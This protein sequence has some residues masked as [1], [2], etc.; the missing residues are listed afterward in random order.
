MKKYSR[1]VMFLFLSVLTV[2]IGSCKKED[3][4]E[5]ARS[6][7]AC[8]SMAADGLLA[9][10]DER[11]HRFNGKVEENTALCRGGDKAARYRDVPWMDW[12]NYWG[13]GDASSKGPDKTSLDHLS[14]TG[15]G[16]DGALLDLEYQ[17]MELIEFNLFDNYTYKEYVKGIEGR[18]GDVIK[19]WDEM[20]LPADH[21][22][23]QDVGG[24]GEQVCD[25][26]L[27][28]NR[29][30]T[31]VCN[32][33]MNPLMGSTNTLFARNVQ[34]ETS[35][36]M[37]GETELV[38]NRHGDRLGLLKPD[39]QLI[40]RRLFTRQQSDAAAC[41]NGYGSESSGEAECD[42]I[43]APFFNVLAAFWIQ[44]M[45]HDWFS[46]LQD[47]HNQ[48]EYMKVGCDSD[49]AE[50][51][52]CRPDDMME[53]AYVAEDS[54]P[55][56]FTYKGESYLDRAPKTFRNTNTAWWDAS[57]IYGYDEDSR[58]R[59]KRDPQDTAK[60]LMTPRGDL[61]GAGDAQGYLPLLLDS[62]PMNPAWAG[63]AA[64]GF[65][66]NWTIGMSFYH[67]VFAREHNAFVE[68][69]REHAKASPEADSGLRDPARPG[70]VIRN[71][72]VSDDEL[73][74]V[75]RLVIAAEIA[76][77]HTIEWTT[78]LLYN[79]P[80]YRGMNANWGGLLDADANQAVQKALAK[81][82][83][84]FSESDSD[85]ANKWYSIFASGPG[86][87]GLGSKKKGWDLSNPKDVN[88]GVNHFGAPFNFPE[89][90]ITVYRLHP[91]LPDALENRVLDGDPNKIISKTPIV[92]SF[93]GKA[94][95]VMTS[96][97]LANTAL[98][99]G[100]QRLGLLTLGNHPNFLQNL[101]MK[102]L[103]TETQEIDVAAL[104]LIR[105]RE[106]GVPR[107]NEFRRQYGLKQL[108]SFN[109]FVDTRLATGSAERTRQEE[110]VLGMREVYGQH[111]CDASK[112]I[113][114]AQANEDG[115][116]IND[117]LGHPDGTTV[118]NI[119]D[120]DAVVGW[121]AEGPRPH[122]FAI[123]ETQFVV[124]I[125]NASRRLYSDRFFTSSYRPE[126]YTK[127][128]I[129]WV[130]NNGPDGK[131]MEKGE[132]NGHEQQVS[133]MKRVLWRT[134]PELRGELD[135]VVNVFDPWARDLGEYYSLAWKPR[136]GA[137][138]DDA[139]K[140]E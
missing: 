41:G 97:G 111:V 8:V 110:Y 91:L 72:D 2:S 76:K 135:T 26:S 31:G 46:H 1:P 129:D 117:C 56:R 89:E 11:A 138:D 136:P 65:P 118:D 23:Y 104:D 73:F 47:G 16:I 38:R 93:R 30:V 131:V 43:K 66:D 137:D 80:L 82:V 79:E 81:V 63:Q 101:K 96:T 53:K 116:F 27:I 134:I 102:R 126:F 48:K 37:L 108:T 70:V 121:L 20:R 124:F 100:R 40:S 57:Q 75:T 59:V 83:A 42:Y 132:P 62:D 130:N 105:D 29:T 64:T 32:D 78:Q 128:G 88:G 99:M 127:F 51:L 140:N 119:E 22:N 28:R 34:F 52:G 54:A 71:A 69:F 55:G 14:P 95:E 15:R 114:V 115:S 61:V 113:S 77:I 67:N 74:E 44:F 25:G 13:T 122:G 17:R 3:R 106:R 7:R 139:F 120:L 123:S 109:D 49:E 133:T 60:L 94:S 107:F 4:S 10:S 5:Y 21:P 18:P 24:D 90:F 87:L 112:I 39:P 19:V 45:N 103:E 58:K 125:I 68:S 92:S 86:I 98:S 85:K 33:I 6:T 84:R 35:F 12:A 9:V 36:P 50:Q